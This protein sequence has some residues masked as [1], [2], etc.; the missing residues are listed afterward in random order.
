MRLRWLAKLCRRPWW[1]HR[2]E[3]L[4]C[5]LCA[6]EARAAAIQARVEMLARQRE[7]MLKRVEREPQ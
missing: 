6:A 5:D 1:L 4:P 3:E 7:L 2:H